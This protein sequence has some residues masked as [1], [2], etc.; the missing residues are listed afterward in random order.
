MST[1]QIE[2]IVV[3]TYASGE[4]HL[5]LRVITNSGGKVSL[6][7]GH[8]RKSKRRFGGSFDLFD[9]GIFEVK[10]GHG[11]LLNILNYKPLPTFRQLRENLEKLGLASLVCECFDFLIPEQAHDG[12]ATYRLLAECLS[13]IAES[14]SAR[15]ALDA[16]L[17][18]IGSLLHLAGLGELNPKPE[19]PGQELQVLLRRIEAHC[20]RKLQSAVI[21][22]GLIREPSS[23][24][25]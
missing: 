9:H 24:G 19:N 11:D 1:Q 22:L 16:S 21:A 2:G 6:F 5:V 18:C 17:C 3:R 7:A 15:Q 10:H 25:A 4:A 13:N 12:E 8:A 20:D 23:A 14:Q